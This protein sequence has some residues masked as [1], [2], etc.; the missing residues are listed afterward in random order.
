MGV[1]MF[2]RNPSSSS[3]WTIWLPTMTKMEEREKDKKY[4]LDTILYIT[5][6]IPG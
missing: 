5:C 1:C 2:V 6:Y 4:Q 3:S